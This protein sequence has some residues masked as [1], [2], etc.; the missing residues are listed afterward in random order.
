MKSTLTFCFAAVLLSGCAGQV[1]NEQ[2]EWLDR[3][4]V[5]P[6]HPVKHTPEE[7]QAL[8][9]EEQQLHARAEA[10]RQ[11]MVY[12]KSRGRRIEQLRELQWIDDGLRPV[13]RALAGGPMPYR[14]LP[15]PDPGNAGGD[16]G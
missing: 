3:V 10:V 7:M 8:R 2:G 15:I 16:G 5:L 13:Q 9:A 4:S 6:A 12:E 14:G 11:Q 1:Y